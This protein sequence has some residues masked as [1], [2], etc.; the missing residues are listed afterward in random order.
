MLSLV[1]SLRCIKLDDQV[2]R[3]GLPVL[4]AIGILAMP[5]LAHAYLDPGTGSIIL[6]ALIGGL[7]GAAALARIYWHRLKSFFRRDSPTPPPTDQNDD[8]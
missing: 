6:Q 1:L 3:P 4:A 8:A 7:I 2:M 5:R